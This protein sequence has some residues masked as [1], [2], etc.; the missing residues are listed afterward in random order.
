M[1][2][3]ATLFIAAASHAAAE[4]PI[5]PA[6]PARAH[7]VSLIS[8]DDYPPDARAARAEGVVL[9]DLEVG[10]NGRVTNCIVTTSSGSPSLDA[11]TCRLV[12]ARARFTPA[13]NAA[14]QPVADHSNG[15]IRWQLP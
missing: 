4:A 10:P 11:T 2:A 1:I 13:R 3:L 12:T 5:R 15:R 7:L 9:F 14:G 8:D 6:V